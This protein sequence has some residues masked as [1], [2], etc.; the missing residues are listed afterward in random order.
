MKAARPVPGLIR[1]WPP[2]K[3]PRGVVTVRADCLSLA[4]YRALPDAVAVTLDGKE[5]ILG[6]HEWLADLGFALYRS[7]APLARI[8]DNA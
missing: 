2:L 7:D 4:D 3:L 6:K 8:V 5:T 1:V